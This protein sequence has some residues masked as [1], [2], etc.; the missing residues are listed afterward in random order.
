MYHRI[1]LRSRMA[2]YAGDSRISLWGP[3]LDSWEALDLTRDSKSRAKEHRFHSLPP[4]T[5]RIPGRASG[6]SGKIE[7][8]SSFLPSQ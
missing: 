7:T 8:R 6:F 1:K 3:T 5:L 2:E 4:D